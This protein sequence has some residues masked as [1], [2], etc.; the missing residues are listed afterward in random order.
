MDF[1]V[2]MKNEKRFHSLELLFV[3]IQ[4][5]VRFQKCHDEP[6]IPNLSSRVVEVEVLEFALHKVMISKRFWQAF[7]SAWKNIGA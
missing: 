7:L 1:E 3:F 6:D 4:N 5:Y 2:E